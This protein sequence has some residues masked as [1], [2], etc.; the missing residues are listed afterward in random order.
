MRGERMEIKKTTFEFREKKKSSFFHTSLHLMP[1]I[2]RAQ[3]AQRYHMNDGGSNSTCPRCFLHFF[4]QKCVLDEKKSNYVRKKKSQKKKK[5]YPSKHISLKT[6]VGRNHTALC[7]MRSEKSHGSYGRGH[8]TSSAVFGLVF[9]GKS[10][11]PRLFVGKGDEGG[12][13]RFQNF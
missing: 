8:G 11:K 2:V 7:A 6:R 1:L 9:G 13:L 3:D 10:E 5:L 4:R 12:S